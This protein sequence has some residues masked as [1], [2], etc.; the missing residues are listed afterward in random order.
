MKVVMKIIRKP[1]LEN[2]NT[3]PMIKIANKFLSQHGFKIDDRVE[4]E[5]KKDELIIKKIKN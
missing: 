4:I 1:G 3:T 5:Y 2:Y